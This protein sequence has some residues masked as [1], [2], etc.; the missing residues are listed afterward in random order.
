MRN[1]RFENFNRQRDIA[2]SSPR[3]LLRGK[4]SWSRFLLPS[5]RWQLAASFGQR[6]NL[7]RLSCKRELHLPTASLH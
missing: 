1:D 6:A 2:L 3:A 7:S 5:A 4:T